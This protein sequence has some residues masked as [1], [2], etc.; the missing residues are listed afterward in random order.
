MSTDVKAS[1]WSVARALRSAVPTLLFGL[2]LWAAVCLALYIAFWLAL[3]NAYWAGATAAIVCQPS[4]GASLRKG[5]FR[6]VGTIVG[7]VAIVVLTA[8][9]PQE[10]DGFLLGFWSAACALVA[11]LLRNSPACAAALAGYTSAIIGSDELGATGGAS[12]DVFMLAVTRASEIGIGII[13]AGVV[14]AATDFGG[15]RRLLA[16]QFA[17][18]SAEIAGGLT[19]KFSLAGP[20]E[21][22][23]RPIQRDLVRRVIALDPVIDQAFGEDSDLE[24]HSPVLQAAVNGLFAALSGW[25]TAALHLELLPIDQGQREVD[26][27]FANIPH[28]TIWIADPHSVRRACSSAVRSLTASPAH[29]S[30]LRL[31]ADQTA[32]ALIG[33]RRAVDG[34]LMLIDTG[35]NFLW[36][37]PLRFDCPTS[38]HLL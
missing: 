14:F 25:R 20:T 12:G 13:C 2:R 17:A 35:R 9:F 10:R 22:E 28:P 18:I 30:S 34:L 4:L 15:A 33:I 6:M 26:I 21:L 7:A 27:I 19:D 11:T 32:D 38:C 36:L 31:L 37:G 24:F 1:G 3:V 29:T 23:T 8:C 16:V 5:W